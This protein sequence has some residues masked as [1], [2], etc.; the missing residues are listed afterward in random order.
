MGNCSLSVKL[1]TRTEP[2]HSV[3]DVRGEN[4]SLG[5]SSPKMK[6]SKK[7]IHHQQC[8]AKDAL[9]HKDLTRSCMYN[10]SQACLRFWLCFLDMHKVRHN[11]NDTHVKREEPP[12]HRWRPWYLSITV[13]VPMVINLTFLQHVQ[14]WVCPPD[15]VIC[16]HWEGKR[17][18][19]GATCF[20]LPQDDAKWSFERYSRNHALTWKAALHPLRATEI[21]RTLES[22]LLGISAWL[23]RYLQPQSRFDSMTS[24][25]FPSPWWKYSDCQFLLIRWDLSKWNVWCFGFRESVKISSNG[26]PQ[27]HSSHS[28]IDV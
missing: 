2:L 25:C 20:C 11:R 5:D 18:F 6:E 27:D 26:F 8:H 28:R 23:L 19:C 4:S 17:A 1:K 10:Q 9:G 7:K 24:L 14:C 21:S 3:M 15:N 12:T 16:L 13:D 22:Q